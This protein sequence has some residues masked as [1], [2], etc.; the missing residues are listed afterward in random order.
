MKRFRDKNILIKIFLLILL[1][2]APWTLANY[3]DEINPAILVQEDTSFYEINT[4]DISLS[5][6]LFSNIKYSYQNHYF[7]NFNPNSPIKCFGKIVG[8]SVNNEGFF[9]SIGANPLINLLLQSA[10]FLIGI[11]FIKKDSSVYV[12]NKTKHNLAMF[13]QTYLFTFSFYAEQRFYSGTIYNFQFNNKLSYLII[14][15]IFYWINSNLIFLLRQRIHKLLYLIPLSFLFQAIFQGTNLSLF[16]IIYSYFGIYSII[17]EKYL[18]KFN[19][20]YLFLSIIWLLNSTGRYYLDPGKLRGFTNS[21]YEFNSN[22]Y[23]AVL[24]LLVINGIYYLFSTEIKNFDFRIFIDNFSLI[25]IPLVLISYIG[26]NFPIINIFVE[27]YFGL[28]RNITTQT[29]PFMF[30]EWSEKLSWRGMYQ[31]AETIGE[32]Y[33]LC[34]MLLLY[35]YFSKIKLTNI[36]KVSFIFSL[37]GLYFSDNRTATMLVL[38]FIISK[39]LIKY[40]QKKYITV[41]LV[42]SFISFLIYFI[43]YQNFIYPYEYLSSFLYNKSID[44]KIYYESSSFLN[45]LDAEYKSDNIFTFIFG[46]FSVL[47]FLFNRSE[48]WALFIARYNPTFIELLFGTGPLTFGNLYGEINVLEPE[49]FYLPHSSLLSYLV[50]FGFIGILF[51]IAVIFKTIYLNRKK[52]NSFN[53]LFLIFLIVNIFKNDSLNYI[54]NFTNYF[55]LFLIIFKTPSYVEKEFLKYKSKQ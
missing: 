10:V 49:A 17:T 14:F 40:K 29:N 43:G 41:S 42:L 46:I 30:N 48:L 21:I 50:F 35:L 9:I 32:F 4:C 34:L 19:K 7:F 15:I 26:S 45:F 44:Y 36:N 11:S 52:I 55:L 2:V 20:Y 5:E 33:G 18:S 22:L 8:V 16:L 51:L 3:L 38:T 24:F 31:S 23:W 37:M 6:F 28:Q 12:Y 1:M 53:I 54:A 39:L 47:S 25:S 13:L 27:Y